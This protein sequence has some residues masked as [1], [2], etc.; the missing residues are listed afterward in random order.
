MLIY[1]IQAD[2]KAIAA[3]IRPTPKGV[4]PDDEY[5]T[6][7]FLEG[8]G[9]GQVRVVESLPA[10]VA[11]SPVTKADWPYTTLLVYQLN[12][13]QLVSCDDQDNGSIMW[14]DHDT[15]LFDL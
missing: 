1:R 9:A 12:A 11:F 6:V 4:K 15:C 3:A 5:V 13:L 14:T 7:S 2:C 10:C 8:Q